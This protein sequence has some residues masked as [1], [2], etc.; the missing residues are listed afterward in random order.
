[1]QR[2][3][4]HRTV[5]AVVAACAMFALTS[6]ASG[7]FNPSSLKKK[8][9]EAASAVVGGAAQ[10]G[11]QSG[12]TGTAVVIPD[13]ESPEETINK[14]AE[15]LRPLFDIRSVYQG[16]FASKTNAQEF[17]NNCRQADYATQ[18]ARVQQAVAMSPEARVREEYTY[19]RVMEKF[20]E[21][22]ATLTT[23]QLIPEINN[24]IETAYAE[25][26]KGPSRA[27]AA[28]EAAEA[29]VLVADGILLVTPDHPDVT[30]LRAD[31]M[32]AAESMGAAK[33]KVYT[34]SFHK[35][36]A[37]KIVFSSQPIVAGQENPA[38]LRS[39]FTAQDDIYGMMYF[40]GTFKEVS[41]GSG[42]G[43]TKLFVDGNE[44]VSYDFNLPA[45][46]AA[47]AWLKSE[48]IPDPASSTTRG[49]AMFTKA[50]SE[51][52]PRRHAIKVQTLDGDW[53][54]L[55]EGEFTLDCTGGLDRVADVHTR[56]GAQKL[57]AVRLPEP[58]MRNAALEKE[59]MAALRDWKE[60]PLKVVI[61]DRDWTIQYHPIT[62]A[63]T[64][65][66][67]NTTVA[68]KKPDGGCRMFVISFQ[69]QYAGG[70]YGKAQ[71]YGVGDSA[72]LP[73]DHV[74]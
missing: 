12:Q 50:I 35:E 57:A 25:K 44:K 7:Q 18:R 42:R 74:K 55:A 60:K 68:M 65:R 52:S 31:A 10:S 17:Y 51:L 2:I 49:A 11:Q 72:D 3:P 27:G 36:H 73:C 20:P 1:M 63:I 58:A 54:V 6:T 47:H 39:S 19:N 14:A 56:I 41:G 32:A 22:F 45:D 37:G 30:R 38:A 4:F 24:A 26:G 16:Q 5:T 46:Q 34:G 64:S 21:H 67:I 70:K 48:I 23:A 59:C 28:L 15:A 62:G 8:A 33:E 29:A 61:T 66:I 9:K 53:K 43:Y 13:G 69:Q 40:R 71:Q